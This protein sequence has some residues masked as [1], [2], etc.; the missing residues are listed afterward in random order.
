[1][2]LPDKAFLTAAVGHGAVI[3]HEAHK[4]ADTAGGLVISQRYIHIAG[5]TAG[6][7]ALVNQT[8]KSAH[9]ARAGAVSCVGG[10]AV[11]RFAAKELTT[12]KCA[13]Y[14]AYAIGRPVVKGLNLGVFY[15]QIRDGAGYNAKETEVFGGADL[16]TIVDLEIG[17]GVTVAIE[18][19]LKIP[20]DR[21]NAFCIE[22]KVRIQGYKRIHGVRTGGEGLEM[23]RGCHD[24]RIFHG[25]VA[26]GHLACLACELIGM[27]RPGYT[28]NRA[29]D[30]NIYRLA[31][32]QP[33]KGQ[34]V[35]V[36]LDGAVRAGIGIAA[37]AAEHVAE[38]IA[39]IFVNEPCGI[40]QSD[41]GVRLHIHLAV[42]HGTANGARG[43]RIADGEV[44][45]GAEVTIQVTEN[46]AGRAGKVVQSIFGKL[47][48]L[49]GVQ[50][51]AKICCVIVQM[52]VPDVGVLEQRNGVIIVIG[53]TI[54]IEGLRNEFLNSRSGLGFVVA[55]QHVI[56]A[57]NIHNR[58][59]V[60][61]HV[62]TAQIFPQTI[63]CGIE[64]AGIGDILQ[65]IELIEG[66]F[67][68]ALGG[69]AGIECAQRLIIVADRFIEVVVEAEVIGQVRII[70]LLLGFVFN[71][72]GKT[73]E[74]GGDGLHVGIHVVLDLR[75]C[76]TLPLQSFLDVFQ[77]QLN[78]AQI[79]LVDHHGGARGVVVHAEQFLANGLERANKGLTKIPVVLL[80]LFCCVHGAANDTAR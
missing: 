69:T 48:D 43:S 40:R 41:A 64:A 25:A 44:F 55:G 56:L 66:V 47:L 36:H 35:S 79:H 1:M 32:G 53:Q 42:L 37:H 50:N 62:F 34:D 65:L 63:N 23:I 8:G 46:V 33:G 57:Q 6:Y 13:C 10:A 9:I 76:E 77:L 75:Q 16:G 70:L 28:G 21:V 39:Q 68:V 2:I 14:D 60:C 26:A 12:G 59:R 3:L 17:D 74:L 54:G 18:G 24:I 80:C 61:G 7:G 71:L 67:D 45:H 49:C 58:A 29:V 22:I 19:A 11:H 38:A 73:G 4:S 72:R 52:V 20:H 27:Q 78:F 30:L 31:I 51:C 5:D 15:R